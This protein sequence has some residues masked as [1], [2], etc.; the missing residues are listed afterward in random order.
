MFFNKPNFKKALSNDIYTME[1]MDIPQLYFA[2]NLT[3]EKTRH[4]FK[5]TM[6]FYFMRIGVKRMQIE[7][8]PIPNLDQLSPEKADSVR[9]KIL[10]GYMLTETDDYIKITCPNPAKYSYKNTPLAYAIY[11]GL[12]EKRYI[13]KEYD[14][15]NVWDIFWA[16][17][18]PDHS[19][20]AYM[21]INQDVYKY[22]D[23]EVADNIFTR[24]GDILPVHKR[25]FMMPE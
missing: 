18:L 11:F 23:D 1:Y 9:N 14:A 4:D 10:D 6:Y 17:W 21:V 12:K 15:S 8:K 13:V 2:N 22:T 5:M 19:R 3:D 16:E 7:G 24:K 25:K 20:L